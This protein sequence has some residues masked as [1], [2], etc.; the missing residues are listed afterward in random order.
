MRLY[1]MYTTEDRACMVYIEVGDNL[2]TNCVSAKGDSNYT[3]FLTT[4]PVIPEI[5]AE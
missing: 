3:N 1:P 5:A 4:A 2:V